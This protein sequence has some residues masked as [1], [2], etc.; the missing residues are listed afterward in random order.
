MW[1]MLQQEVSD[2]YV[3]ATGMSHTVREFV[4][5]AFSAAGLDWQDHVKMDERFMRP[6][7][8]PELRGDASK[9]RANSAGSLRRRLRSWWR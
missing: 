3:V 8:V 5:M 9:A 6:A 2:D 7:K 1:L 4:E